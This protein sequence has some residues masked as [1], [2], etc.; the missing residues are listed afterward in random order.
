MVGG[1]QPAVAVTGLVMGLALVWRRRA[2][3]TVLVVVF[4][5]GVALAVLGVDSNTFFAPLLAMVVAVSSAAYH[6]SRP[7]WLSLRHWPWAGLRS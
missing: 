6:A 5:A 7:S 2:P 3:L 1:P 4:A